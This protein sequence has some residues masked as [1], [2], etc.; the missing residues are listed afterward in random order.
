MAPLNIV[1]STGKD[2]IKFNG[3]LI[4]GLADQ[5]DFAVT[6]PNDSMAVKTGKN[7]NSLFAYDYKGLQGEAMM[8]LV[9]GC[10]DD[11]F[12]LGLLFQMDSNP[13][14][15]PLLTCQYTKVVG[16]GTGATKPDIYVLSG[17][18]FKKRPEVKDNAEG[19]VEQAVTIWTFAFAN[20]QRSI[21]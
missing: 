1:A 6:I 11:N 3:R 9:R 8:R 15:F 4:T 5:D 12:F 7:G 2:I 13:P 20:V 10:D 16:D 14:A 17:G 21:G 19:D 18:V